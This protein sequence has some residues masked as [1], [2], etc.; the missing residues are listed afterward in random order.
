MSTKDDN[1]KLLLLQVSDNGKFVETCPCKP[2]FKLPLWFS[3]I[4]SM[5]ELNER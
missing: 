4:C 5:E 2:T 1:S 3:T